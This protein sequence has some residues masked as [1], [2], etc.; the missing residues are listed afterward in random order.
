MGAPVQRGFTLVEIMIS[1]VVLALLLMVAIPSFNQFLANSRIRVTADGILN[2]LQRARNEA[3]RRNVCMQLKL[4]GAGW[5]ISTCADAAVEIESR[6][7]G[8]GSQD[9]T[10]VPTGGDTVSFN[11]L[12]RVLPANPSD[13]TAPLTQVN[14]DHATLPGRRLRL[15]IPNGGGV[16]MCDPVVAAGDPRAC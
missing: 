13:G 16:R 2:G 9:V 14:M 7:A 4:T 11:G 1:I 5:V 6:P 15:V 8:E 3:I 12:G 10:V